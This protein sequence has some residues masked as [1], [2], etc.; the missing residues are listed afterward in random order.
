MCVCVKGM[1]KNEIVKFVNIQNTLVFDS[2]LFST[3]T[4]PLPGTYA[5][6]SYHEPFSSVCVTAS[7][8]GVLPSK[9]GA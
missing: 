2:F 8:G 9:Y 5:G 3:I 4:V 6:I 7:G 1:Y